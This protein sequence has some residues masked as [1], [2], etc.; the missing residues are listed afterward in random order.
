M[1][2]VSVMA[3][4]IGSKAE[5][6][7]SIS[8]I[9]FEDSNANG[10]QD[11]NEPGIEGVTVRLLDDSGTEIAQKTTDGQGNIHLISFLLICIR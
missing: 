1:S 7:A 4:G 10:Q 5:G 6:T 9:L 8:G 11:A 3:K 2:S